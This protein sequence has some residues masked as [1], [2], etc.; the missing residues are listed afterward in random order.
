MP[1]ECSIV[2]GVDALADEIGVLGGELAGIIACD[3]AE[4]RRDSHLTSRMEIIR[5][6]LG[7]GQFVTVTKYPDPRVT[8]KKKCD[9]NVWIY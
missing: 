8:Q 3:D 7:L 1:P 9:I 6:T 2:E 4:E 5:V